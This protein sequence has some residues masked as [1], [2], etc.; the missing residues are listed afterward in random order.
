MVQRVE[1]AAVLLVVIVAA[2]TARKEA[3]KAFLLIRLALRVYM[4]TALA[5]A[6]VVMLF[7]PMVAL[8]VIQAVQAAQ[9][10]IMA[11]RL[12][13]VLRLRA[14][15][16]AVAA[17]HAAEVREVPRRDLQPHRRLALE[18]PQHFT[19]LVVAVQEECHRQI[20]RN[21]AAPATRA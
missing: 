10:E 7:M 4:L 1:V 13:G 17:V 16:V 6:L 14:Q 11:V 3:G 8:T 21:P 19:A 5:V 18:M 15:K 20:L 2:Q 9:T 12:H